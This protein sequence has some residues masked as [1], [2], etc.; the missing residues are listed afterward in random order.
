MNVGYKTLLAA[1]RTGIQDLWLKYR[2]LRNRI[3]HEVRL[4][5]TEYYTEL[6]KEVKDCKSCWKLV[7]NAL[8]VGLYG[9]Y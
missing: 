7:K 4:A 1:K 3:T 2:T 6:F 5:K 8:A 9:R